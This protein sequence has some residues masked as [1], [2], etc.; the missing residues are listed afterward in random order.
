[1]TMEKLESNAWFSDVFKGADYDLNVVSF[2]MSM[3]DFDE[4]Y[5]LYRGGEGQNF[6]N[7]NDED[8][9]KAWDLE[10]NSVDAATRTAACN[11]IQRI[12]GDRALIVPIYASKTGIAAKANLNGIA[13]R[14]L[15]DYRL[16]D[17]SWGE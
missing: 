4:N 3:N 5:A 14:S 17:W 1:M 7:M 13:A 16:T 8:L 6:G 10:H 11:D 15:K 2:S 9:N 12:M